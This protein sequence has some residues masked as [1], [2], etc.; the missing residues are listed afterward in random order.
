M[1]NLLAVMALFIL[2]AQGAAPLCAQQAADSAETAALKSEIAAL[3]QRIAELEKDYYDVLSENMQ[4][5]NRLR[6]EIRRLKD[7]L[8]EAKALPIA[9]AP[10]AAPALA[11]APSQAAKETFDKDRE[12]REARMRAGS[13]LDSAEGASA[14]KPSAEK[15]SGP[16][17]DN[18][19]EKGGGSDK[20]GGSSF[21]DK[22][23]PV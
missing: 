19:P 18:E 13:R 5:Q 9:G 20:K 10:A 2:A 16:A 21:W 23:V 12:Y 11:P 1:K 7:E 3:K 14:K 4:R 15:D 8:E 22:A 17:K 6:A